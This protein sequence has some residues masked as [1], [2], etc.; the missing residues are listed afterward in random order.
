M[1]GRSTEGD[2]AMVDVVIVNGAGAGLFTGGF[3]LW[4]NMVRDECC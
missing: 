4:S 3:S 2:T 1:C